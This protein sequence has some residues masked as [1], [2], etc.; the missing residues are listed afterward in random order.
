MGT[1]NPFSSPYSISLPVQLNISLIKI[2]NSCLTKVNW[3]AS[4][5]VIAWRQLRNETEK[6]IENVI[7]IKRLPLRRRN[8]EDANPR[9]IRAHE[10]LTHTSAHH[11]ETRDDTV[12]LVADI[13]LR[14]IVS[15][16]IGWHGPMKNW[17]RKAQFIYA[18]VT[19][20]RY[21]EFRT[22]KRVIIVGMNYLGGKKVGKIA[23][24]VFLKFW[25]IALWIYVLSF[26]RSFERINVSG[27][28]LRRFMDLLKTY[29]RNK[30]SRAIVPHD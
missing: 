14:T 19:T 18:V 29:P 6:K 3:I 10:S 9:G 11:R 15:W 27:T 26:W 22:Y 20:R 5:F 8:G 23:V 28:L 2:K 17:F 25:N 24:R 7:D 30:R 1:R 16:T 21:E 12:R 4:P 13:C